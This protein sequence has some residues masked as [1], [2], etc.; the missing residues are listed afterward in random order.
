MNILLKTIRVILK[1]LGILLIGGGVLFFVDNT[2]GFARWFNFYLGGPYVASGSEM[3][4]SIFVILVVSIIPGLFFYGL[5]KTVKKKKEAT[6]WE[7]FKKLSLSIVLFFLVSSLAF[8]VLG[9][10]EIPIEETIKIEGLLYKKNTEELYT[11]IVREDIGRGFLSKTS[12]KNGKKHGIAFSDNEYIPS[13]TQY[14]NGKRHGR[15]F[16]SSSFG[17][18]SIFRG[19]RYL[20]GEPMWKLKERWNFYNF[21]IKKRKKC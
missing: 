12:Y 7:T 18:F 4:K 2:L 11:G 16:Y 8:I 3:S 9:K 14:K 13:Y 6:N 10:E 15:S 20:N 19:E 1:I 21:R 17:S 5:G